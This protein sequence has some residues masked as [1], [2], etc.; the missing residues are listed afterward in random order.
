MTFLLFYI[1]A[2]V[3]ACSMPDDYRI[4]TNLQ[5][6]EEADLIVLGRTGSGPEEGSEPGLDDFVLL[7]LIEILKGPPPSEPLRVFGRTDWNGQPIPPLPSSLG[8]AHFSVGLGACVRV[9]YPENQL[10]VAMFVNTPEGLR[11]IGNSWARE[12]ED[13]ESEDDIWVQAIHE[14][15][16]LISFDEASERER[17]IR[18]RQSELMLQADVASHAIALDLDRHLNHVHSDGDFVPPE[19]WRV[20]DHPEGI[21]ATVTAGENRAALTCSLGNNNVEMMTLLGDET[22]RVALL[23]GGQSYVFTDLEQSMER[24]GFGEPEE[25]PVL[26]GTLDISDDLLDILSTST[27]M[28]GVTVDDLSIMAPA[29]DTMLRFSRRCGVILASN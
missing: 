17:A 12:I 16:G 1:S 28:A 8:E 6:V 25:T 10:V 23:V 3:W 22:T 27:G 13:V 15:L 29:G 14:Y 18:Q 2:P 7:E 5:L 24:V 9:F 20:I 21:V 11:Q 19:Y 4:P 26:R